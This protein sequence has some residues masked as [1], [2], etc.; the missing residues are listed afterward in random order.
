MAKGVVLD[1]KSKAENKGLEEVE[2]VKGQNKINDN[3]SFQMQL[4]DPIPY[5]INV[6]SKSLHYIENK[7]L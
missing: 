4:E 5:E 7:M 1:I 3:L 6:G 2:V